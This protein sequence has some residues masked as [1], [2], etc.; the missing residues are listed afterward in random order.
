MLGLNY[1]WLNYGHDFGQAAWPGGLWSHDGMSNFESTSV[2]DQDFAMLKSKGAHVIRVFV[3]AD[4]R[5]SPEFDSQGNITG[6]DRFFF[7]DFDTILS[8]ASLHDLYVIPVLLDFYWLDYP[9]RVGG[10]QLGGHADAI[11]NTSKRQTFLDNALR[12]L[13]ERYGNEYRIV[14]WEVINEPEWTSKGI[15]GGGTVGPT[16]T[17]AEMQAFVQDVINYT[18]R[19]AS[20]PITIGSAKGQWL[21][22]WLGLGLDFYQFHYYDSNELAPPFVPYS[23]LGLDKPAILGEFPTGSTAITV[24]HYLSATWENGYAGALAWSLNGDD[25]FSNFITPGT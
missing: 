12:P 7:D 2:V 25:R 11:T 22:Y 8:L 10:V 3:F 14:A 23:D 18:H 20:Q 24:T 6:F 17:I 1:P 5:A 19:Y 13:L 15:P 21:T 4:G 16:V 9:R